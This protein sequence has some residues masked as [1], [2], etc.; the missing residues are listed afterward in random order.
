MS[1]RNGGGED[2]IVGRAV[3]SLAGGLVGLVGWFVVNVL[4]LYG[5]WLFGGWFWSKLGSVDVLRGK[6]GETSWETFV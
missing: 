4:L 3:G 1:W 6:T 2:E 5:C